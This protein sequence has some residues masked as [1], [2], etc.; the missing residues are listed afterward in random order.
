M[1]NELEESS[2]KY[3]LPDEYARIENAVS[4]SKTEREKYI[5]TVKGYIKEVMDEA[6][7]SCELLG[8]SKNFYS[9]YNKMIS[10]NHLL[11]C[12]IQHARCRCM[13]EMETRVNH[14]SGTCPCVVTHRNPEVAVVINQLSSWE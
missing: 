8:R 9:I 7:L 10:Q 1:K 13:C 14:R 4:K 12:G 11:E 3:V 2:F 6:K 5:E